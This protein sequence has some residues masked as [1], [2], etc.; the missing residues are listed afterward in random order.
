MDKS[1][2]QEVL[3]AFQVRN[4]D[5][6]EALSLGDVDHRVHTDLSTFHK[7]YGEQDITVAIKK[8]HRAREEAD[9]TKEYTLYAVTVTVHPTNER[10]VVKKRYRDFHAL[11][12]KLR[13]QELPGLDQLVLPGKSWFHALSPRVVEERQRGLE[14]YLNKMLG[15]YNCREVVPLRHFLHVPK[16]EAVVESRASVSRRSS[17]TAADMMSLAQA[18]EKYP[19]YAWA[20]AAAHS[21]AREQSGSVAA[22]AVLE[23]RGGRMGSVSRRG[24]GGSA[25]ASASGEAGVGAEAGAE[26]D[27][28]EERKS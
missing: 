17:T 28:W 22:A 11:H 16:E 8:T 18:A 15:M 2:Q 24:S 25:G 9:P 20:A 4:L 13:K 6:G 5:T 12:Q 10:W 1:P 26:A 21:R 19:E 14:Q 27:A 23:P 7:L 3:A